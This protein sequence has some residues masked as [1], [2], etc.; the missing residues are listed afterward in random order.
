MDLDAYASYITTV[1]ETT[2]PTDHSRINFE[3]GFKELLFSFGCATGNTSIVSKIMADHIDLNDVRAYGAPDTNLNS[4]S[5]K[6]IAVWEARWNTTFIKQAD[7]EPYDEYVVRTNKKPTRYDNTHPFIKACRNGHI[8][9]VKTLYK[10]YDFDVWRGKNAALK[11]ATVNDHADIVE[12][13]ISL[14]GANISESFSLENYNLFGIACQ[15]ASLKVVSLLLSDKRVDPYYPNNSPIK[16]AAEVSS[17]KFSDNRQ[18][19]DVINLLLQDERVYTKLDEGMT[20]SILIHITD[21]DRLDSL[22]LLIEGPVRNIFIQRDVKYFLAILCAIGRCGTSSNILEYVLSS[23]FKSRMSYEITAE[24]L[25]SVVSTIGKKAKRETQRNVIRVIL[26]DRR[27]RAASHD[28]VRKI[29][30]RLRWYHYQNRTFYLFRSIER[31]F[32]DTYGDVSKKKIK[33]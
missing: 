32:Q 17:E 19:F 29:L 18:N 8:D 31:I 11:D 4:N 21:A 14:P 9:I 2:E 5:N 16:W 3:L 26:E 13:L 24:H 27:A 10:S 20:S 15:N 7:D 22:K 28:L 23:A 25:L 33:K 30:R 12:F 6:S 1:L